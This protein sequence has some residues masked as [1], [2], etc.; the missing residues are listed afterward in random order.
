M[1][2]PSFVSYGLVEPFDLA[3]EERAKMAKLSDAR[4]RTLG[5]FPEDRWPLPL[6]RRSSALREPRLVSQ[7][8]GHWEA[9]HVIQRGKGGYNGIANYLPACTECNR[10]RW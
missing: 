8:K 10:L 5:G 7:S 2:P 3:G 1:N 4:K 9:D 6:L